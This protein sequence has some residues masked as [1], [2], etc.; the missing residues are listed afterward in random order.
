MGISHWIQ[1]TVALL[2]G[3][4]WGAIAPSP[5]AATTQVIPGRTG[6]AIDPLHLAQAG[7]TCQKVL[8]RSGLYVREQP[9]VTGRALGAI[10]YGRNV[11]VQPGGS[12][13]LWTRISAPLSG[14]VWANWLG[15]CDAAAY[16]PPANC[17][18]VV[19][20]TGAVIRQTPSTEGM[21]VGQVARGRRVTIENRGAN[22]WVPI[23]APLEGYISSADLTDCLSRISLP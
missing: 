12:T 20:G 7:N 1:F 6:S 9:T 18:L 13:R 10:Q 2:V 3:T 16:A 5:A 17:R 15:P 22:G 21:I 19:S 8:A 4:N 14:Y 11:T 23:S